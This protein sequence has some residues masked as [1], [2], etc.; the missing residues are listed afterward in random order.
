[1]ATFYVGQRVRFAKAETM[2]GLPFEGMEC[3]VTKAITHA[4]NPHTGEVF[5]ADYRIDF[6][7]GQALAVFG[8]QLEPIV[9]D[10]RK[11]VEWSDCL[12]QPEGIAA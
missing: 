9:D 7:C 1:M 3:R 10:G 4:L 2:F 12:W 8:R 6:D 5:D 11:V